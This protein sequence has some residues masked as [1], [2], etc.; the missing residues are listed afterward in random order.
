MS[1]TDEWIEYAF[2]M[3]DDASVGARGGDL[4]LVATRLEGLSLDGEVERQ[5]RRVVRRS[6]TIDEQATGRAVHDLY[7]ELA[8]W[9]M[10]F[11]V[12]SGY[13]RRERGL[14]EDEV[15]AAIGRWFSR[16]G[17]ELA[18]AERAR[19]AEGIIVKSMLNGARPYLLARTSPEGVAMVEAPLLVRMEHGRFVVTDEAE[20]YLYH[21]DSTIDSF[22]SDYSLVAARMSRELD[23]RSF[24][25]SSHTVREM[26]AK[27][28]HVRVLMEALVRDAGRLGPDEQDERFASIRRGVE[29]IRAN[30]DV[31][32]RYR[33]EVSRIWES[34]TGE[35]AMDR[36][37]ETRG[38][39]L[40]DLRALDEGLRML[41][42]VK[43]WMYDEYVTLAERC[44]EA[45]RH[46]LRSSIITQLFSLDDL[47]DE[48]AHADVRDLEWLDL[49]LLPATRP[50]ARVPLSMPAMAT[51]D[52]MVRATAVEEGPSLPDYDAMLEG[53]NDADSAAADASAALALSR[54]FSAWLVRGGGT[55]SDWLEQRDPDLTYA[56]MATFD[57]VRLVSSLLGADKTAG[58]GPATGAAAGRA[59]VANKRATPQGH[60]A[61][62]ADGSWLPAALPQDASGLCVRA[63]KTGD[64]ARYLG[65]YGGVDI[66]G[67]MDDVRFEVTRDAGE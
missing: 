52:G 53:D 57:L 60:V 40:A 21:L 18:D 5:L 54:D 16:L 3:A 2:A 17:I 26:V 19:L 50:C 64:E 33:D 6:A 11:M 23:S 49:L 32:R 29:G 22:A 28:G 34:W 66:H 10:E 42:A 35:G 20:N 13:V 39:R 67:T 61:S 25:K 8:R 45:M 9:L 56:D 43:S 46:Y 1:V 24:G 27:V 7:G 63:A 44:E 15:S 59:T 37:R 51:L 31:E 65:S 48:V 12:A 58:A 47:A 62:F 14:S 4:A 55:L 36:M 38:D 41:L 30:D